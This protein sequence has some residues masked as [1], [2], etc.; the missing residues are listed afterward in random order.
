MIAYNIVLITD[1]EEAKTA[2]ILQ[3]Q[4]GEFFLEIRGSII[5]AFIQAVQMAYE[6]WPENDCLELGLMD[7]PDYARPI[8]RYCY[9]IMG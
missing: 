8:F 5:R 9:E 3:I 6:T 2:E 7:I 1:L 4:H